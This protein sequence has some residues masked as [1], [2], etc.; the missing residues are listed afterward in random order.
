MPLVDEVKYPLIDYIK[1]AR[2]DSEDKEYVLITSYAPY[3]I[4]FHLNKFKEEFIKMK[5]YDRNQVLIPEVNVL[6]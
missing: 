3:T 5:N 6:A 4:V 2:H 1:N